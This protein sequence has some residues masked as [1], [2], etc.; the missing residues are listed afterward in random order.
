MNSLS[1][2]Y[3][4]VLLAR[5]LRK[6]NQADLA[7]FASISQGHLS[8][9]ENGLIEPLEPTMKQIAR[10]LGFPHNFFYQP[11]RIYG[12]PLSFHP[13]YRKKTNIGQHILES[14]QAELNIRIMHLRRLIK[15]VDLK[16]QFPMPKVEIDEYDNDIEK[17]ADLVRRTWLLPRGPLRN[18]TQ[19]VE[20]AGCI[21]IWCDF[22]N[23]PIDG[24]SY[25]IPDLPQ[26]IFLNRNQPPD[27]MRFSL[28]HEVGHLVMHRIPTPEMEDQAN[29]F[30]SALL[31]P[32]DDI[33]GALMGRITLPAI[34]ALKPIWRVSM[35][36]LVMKA[37]EIGLISSN[38]S[39]YLWQKIN[40]K[41]LRYHEPP[42]LNFD[43]E[44]I[45]LLPTIFKRHIED[46]GYSSEEIAEILNL[47][48]YELIEMY[49][50]LNE[51]KKT[52]LR[53]VS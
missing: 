53:L 5:Q 43:Y 27:R 17:I 6:M 4:L 10:I 25:Q 16:K 50:W 1:F 11:D 40:T 34:A 14:I 48:H 26:C 9:I 12:L 8:K 44:E 47:N 18:L 2:N 24:V 21:V 32:V 33:R 52:Q 41:K 45:Q 19:C 30:A 29:S 51:Y 23:S 36:S 13:M 7:K 28:A 42:E 3:N 22:S 38:Q 35:Q 15:S 46:L 20:Q 37:H 39:R 49:P 31:M